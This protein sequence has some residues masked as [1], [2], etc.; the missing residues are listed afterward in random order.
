MSH[1]NALGSKLYLDVKKIKVTLVS[2]FE[3]T[4]WAPHLQYYIPSLKVTGLLVLEKKIF[5]RF[6]PYMGVEAIFVMW[7][8]YFV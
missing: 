8:K 3:Q 5:K 7:P 6:I 2:S 4:W 1:S